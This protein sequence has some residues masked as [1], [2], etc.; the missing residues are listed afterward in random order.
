LCNFGFGIKEVE[1]SKAEKSKEPTVRVF[2]VDFSTSFD[3]KSEIQNAKWMR[4]V[5]TPHTLRSPSGTSDRPADQPGVVPFQLGLPVYGAYQPREVATATAK[6]I[7]LGSR[8]K[9]PWDSLDINGLVN[10]AK[11][12]EMV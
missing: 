12:L 11:F 4:H 8:S 10:V 7:R 9:S 5:I 3:P 1:E 6:R 2:T